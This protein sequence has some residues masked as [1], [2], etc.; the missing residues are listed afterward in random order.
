MS[1]VLSSLNSAVAVA[2]GMVMVKS[3]ALRLFNWLRFS[4]LGVP[5]VFDVLPVLVV[6]FVPVL[7]VVLVMLF[8]K[9]TVA[10][11]GGLMPSVFFLSRFIC[12]T[13]TST[14]ISALA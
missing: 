2:C 8:C 3:V 7:V 10:L 14:M 1:L 4:W 9:A 13:G 12:R 6:V 11:V 5:V